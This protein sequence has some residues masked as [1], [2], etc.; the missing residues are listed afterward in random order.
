MN[1]SEKNFITFKG[2]SLWELTPWFRGEFW[3]EGEAVVE[4]FVQGAQ[5]LSLQ[6]IVG[7]HTTAN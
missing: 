7:L 4:K 1:A 5:R 2:N 6:P 3:N